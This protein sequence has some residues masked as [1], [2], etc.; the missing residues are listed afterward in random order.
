LKG[1][2]L[3][4]LV[5]P[6]EHGRSS[7]SLRGN[8]KSKSPHNR[9]NPRSNSPHANLLGSSSSRSR[10]NGT[11]T[12]DDGQVIDKHSAYRRLSDANLVYGGSS[13]AS[14]PRKK[15]D[16]DGHGRIEKS[17]MSPYGE[18]LTDDDSDDDMV[19]SSD[20]EDHRGRKLTTRDEGHEQDANDP[21]RAAK[22]LLAAADDESKTCSVPTVNGLKLLT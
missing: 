4:N 3:S 7:F 22:S 13:L 17:N 16:K 19:N 20:E 18:I 21:N 5:L 12:L 6:G 1:A 14:L 10:D 8:S 15:S 2:D 9:Y 11:I